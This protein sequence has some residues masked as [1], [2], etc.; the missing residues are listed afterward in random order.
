MDDQELL[1]RFR[2]TK[3][4]DAFGM[5][6]GRYAG[7]VYNTAAR[8]TGSAADAE[9]AAQECFLALARAETSP[10]SLP[11]WLHRVAVNRALNLRRSAVTRVKHERTAATLNGSAA[12]GAWRAVAPQVDEAIERLPAELREPLLLH[13]LQER[14]Q[15]EVARRLG[16]DQSTVSRRIRSGLDQVRDVLSKR[17]VTVTTDTDLTQAEP[18][19]RHA[20]A[21][22]PASLAAALSEG[23]VAQAV[24]GGAGAVG[25]VATGAGIAETSAAAGGSVAVHSTAAGAGSVAGTSI[26]GGAGAMT[27]K[28]GLACV[29]LAAVV[30]VGSVVLLTNRQEP[31]PAE[32]VAE[33]AEVP[34]PEMPPP[35]GNSHPEPEKPVEEAAV[36]GPTTGEAFIRE[37]IA[38][39]FEQA[40]P[41]AMAAYFH[42]DAE[43]KSQGKGSALVTLRQ[44]PRSVLT[45]INIAETIIFRREDL[46][47]MRA[48]HPDD[49]WDADRVPARMRDAVGC[50]V[51]FTLKDAVNEGKR[52][53]GQRLGMWV[54]VAKKVD[55]EY[56]IVYV[57]D[58]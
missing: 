54:C 39:V 30:T 12:D 58:N 33:I 16:V 55:G 31:P 21:A 51:L 42:P 44:Q 57:D 48:E 18:R 46:A 49:M 3:D 15:E 37:A 47:R 13:F 6:V 8:I 56:K 40:D 10:R 26:L 14:T 2:E 1:H 25:G 4:T 38:A 5:L 9:D 53:D 29:G 45:R 11:A 32:P 50:L 22:V 36:R 35:V 20:K 43:R 17:G 34:E 7:L 52:P 23:V 41:Q 19:A 24:S 28:L 27:V